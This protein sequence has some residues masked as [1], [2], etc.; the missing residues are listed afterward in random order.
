MLFALAAAL[1]TAAPPIQLLRLPD[2]KDLTAQASKADEAE[3]AQLGAA[4]AGQTGRLSPSVVKPLQADLAAGYRELKAERG[5]FPTPVMATLTGAQ[6]P[7]GFDLLVVPPSGKETESAVLFLHG[8]GGSFTLQ[9]WLTARALSGQGWLTV[10]PATDTDA[11]WSDAAGERIVLQSLAFLHARGKRRIVLAGLSNGGSGAARL[12]RKL[13]RD[14]AGLICLSGAA[15][16]GPAKLPVLVVNGD[17]D[18][19]FAVAHA[20]RFAQ[21]HAERTLAVLDGGHFVALRRRDQVAALIARWASA[22]PK[23]AG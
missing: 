21:G 19:M 3:L 23:R 9:C 16:D 1:L 11:V 14:F 22:L 4:A 17:A 18:P 15:G 2:G 5:T 8:W 20:R 13:E 6:R 7:D 10:C 12:S